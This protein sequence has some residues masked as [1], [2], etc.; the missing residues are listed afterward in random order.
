LEGRVLLADHFGNL[1]TNFRQQNFL[2]DLSAWKMEVGDNVISEFQTNYA[3]GR[4]GQPFAIFGSAG[5]LEI[6]INRGNAAKVL[7]ISAGA[8]VTLKKNSHSS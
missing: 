8:P 2:H 4:L 7:D 5:L 6:A 1:L 3:A